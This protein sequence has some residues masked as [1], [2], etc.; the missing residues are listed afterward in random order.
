M[1]S[2]AWICFGTPDDICWF[3]RL[4]EDNFSSGKDISVHEAITRFSSFWKFGMRNDI[5][6][7]YDDVFF[8]CLIYSLQYIWYLP[9]CPISKLPSVILWWSHIGQTSFDHPIEEWYFSKGRFWE[10]C[11]FFRNSMAIRPIAKKGKKMYY[12][13]TLFDILS[14]YRNMNYSNVSFC[15]VITSFYTVLNY[16]LALVM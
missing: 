14:E 15:Y 5:H 3:H 2:L 10:I 4:S 12:C 1:Q 13:N 9:F 11:I 6:V 16:L 8:S 7:Q